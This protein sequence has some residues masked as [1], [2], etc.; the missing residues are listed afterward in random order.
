MNTWRLTAMV[1]CLSLCSISCAPIMVST[2]M[3]DRSERNLITALR[4]IEV[5]DEA[6]SASVGIFLGED[7]EIESLIMNSPAYLAGIREDDRLLAIDGISVTN[8]NAQG[9]LVGR[10][11]SSVTVAIRKRNGE[12]QTIPLKRV[13]WWS[14]ITRDHLPPREHEIEKRPGY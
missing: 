4:S 12:T 1:F 11:G 8:G 5:V 13:A 14:L 3:D 10:P 7:G 9:A 6:R 2:M